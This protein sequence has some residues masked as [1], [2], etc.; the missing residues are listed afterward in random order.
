[1]SY[2]IFNMHL[3]FVTHDYS[4]WFPNAP[5]SNAFCGFLCAKS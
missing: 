3:Y 5:F 1:L 2:D 4:N